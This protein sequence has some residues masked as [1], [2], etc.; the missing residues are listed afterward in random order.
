MQIDKSDLNR[1]WRNS[2]GQ[3]KSY[4]TQVFHS[5]LR[6]CRSLS[7]LLCFPFITRSTMT[8]SVSLSVHTLRGLHHKYIRF[9][10]ILNSKH[11]FAFW[12]SNVDEFK[13]SQSINYRLYSCCIEKTLGERNIYVWICDMHKSIQ[14]T[15][16]K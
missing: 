6:R 14:T 12:F 16:C 2:Y 15:T 10:S 9:S 4:V 8:N 3:R 5:Q 13:I 1:L 7:P 11:Y